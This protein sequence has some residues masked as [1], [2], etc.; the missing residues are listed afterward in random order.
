MDQSDQDEQLVVFDLS[1]ALDVLEYGEQYNRHQDRV[2]QV[3]DQSERGVFLL[4]Q[5]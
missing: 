1:Q 3:P 2:E 5:K 4:R